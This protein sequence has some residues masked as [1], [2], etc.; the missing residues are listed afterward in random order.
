MALNQI[1]E[2]ILEKVINKCIKSINQLESR[3]AIHAYQIMLAWTTF[4]MA[5]QHAAFFYEHDIVAEANLLENILLHEEPQDFLGLSSRNDE[6]TTPVTRVDVQEYAKKKLS[7]GVQW[8]MDSINFS[9]QSPT[10]SRIGS[11]VA[12]MNI[13]RGGDVK[14]KSSEIKSKNLIIDIP[15]EAAVSFGFSTDHEKGTVKYFFGFNGIFLDY[16]LDQDPNK[17]GA[18]DQINLKYIGKNISLPVNKLKEI[19]EHSHRRV[20]NVLVHFINSLFKNRNLT[21]EDF[22]AQE[23]QKNASRAKLK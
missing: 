6:T 12:R 4:S 14:S 13:D 10:F 17:L 22:A 23:K 15:F 5:N 21:F 11:A 18:D 3:Y 20:S 9:S 19:A 7:E 2:H 8:R 16:D 1:Q